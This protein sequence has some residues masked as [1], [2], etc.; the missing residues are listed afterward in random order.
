[1]LF[2][3]LFKFSGIKSIHI[4]LQLLLPSISRLFIFLNWNSIPIKE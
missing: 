1:M 2:Y 4:V 3:L